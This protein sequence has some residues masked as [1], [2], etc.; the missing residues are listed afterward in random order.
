[1]A[2]P[3]TLLNQQDLNI[4]E[5]INNLSDEEKNKLFTENPAAKDYYDNLIKRVEAPRTP[6]D[7][8]PTTFQSSL[9]TTGKGLK[10]LADIAEK[11]KEKLP[12]INLTPFLKTDTILD[13][14]KNI[15]RPLG[16]W[17]DDE[18][19]LQAAANIGL[20]VNST[21]ADIITRVKSGFGSRQLSFEDSKKLLTDQLGKAPYYVEDIEG[22]GTVF[23]AN[24]GDR[25][26]AFNRPGADAGDI[27][28]FIAE[29]ALPLGLDIT[30]QVIATKTLK[31]L[32]VGV[33]QNITRGTAT[34]GASGIAT[35]L[36]EL[37]KL[38]AGQQFFGLNEGTSYI[39]LMKESIEPAL[40][41]GAGTGVFNSL[42]FIGRGVYRAIKGEKMPNDVINQ[43]NEM[44]QNAKKEAN[45]TLK[46]NDIPNFKPTLGQKYKSP[47]LLALEDAFMRV[48]GV[49]PNVSRAYLQNLKDNE[50]A[51]VDFATKLSQEYGEEFGEQAIE[52]FGR[53]FKAAAGD[54]KQ[55]ILDRVG[56]NLKL[57]Q[58]IAGTTIKQLPGYQGAAGDLGIGLYKDLPEE[59][60]T[61]LSNLIK[62][63]LDAQDA[64]YETV[65]QST[66]VYPAT[67]TKT[68]N[69]LSE[70]IESESPTSLFKALDDPSFAKRLFGE[71]DT[72]S[73][74]LLLRLANKDAQGR[75]TT[76]L[77]LGELYETR[78]VL[79]L[80]RGGKKDI[81]LN[82]K[83]VTK[84]IKSVDQDIQASLNKADLKGEKV[85]LGNDQLSPSEAWN[86]AKNEY[87]KANQLARKQFIG[88]LKQG[89]I[90]PSELFDVTM[91]K[92]VKG[93]RTNEY[94]DDLFEVLELGDDALI[95]DLRF[96]FGERLKNEIA[97]QKPSARPAAI[98]EFLDN[99]SGIFKRLYPTKQDQKIFRVAARDLDNVAKA[100]VSYQ[101]AVE[102]INNRFD[103]FLGPED[104]VITN[105]Y[106]I[107]KGTPDESKLLLN[108]R[109][110]QLNKILRT[111]PELQNQFRFHLQKILLNDITTKDPF[112][113][114]I[115]DL[116]SLIKTI[117][118]P[119]FEK[120]YGIFFDTKYINNLKKL[121]ETAQFSNKRINSKIPRE[122]AQNAKDIV[123]QLTMPESLGQRASQFIFG[124]LNRFSVRF[125]LFDKNQ[126]ERAFDNLTRMITDEDVLESFI[127]NRYKSMNTI[128]R[129]SPIGG[130]IAR[131]YDG[132][133]SDDEIPEEVRLIEE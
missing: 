124:P 109:R 127:E 34:A 27:A 48:P 12:N 107:F 99:H 20:D 80:I 92:S 46:P 105:I 3:I 101:E 81:D 47:E 73:K 113:G 58:Q 74:D 29:E 10:G 122:N 83:E 44:L 95:T 38:A 39:D 18:E 103:R 112:Y 24:K 115:I 51:L 123:R 89:K 77:S 97:R 25:L 88:D 61:Y 117:D 49:D 118:D 62:Q 116:D 130:L 11:A 15:S 19:K 31:N 52:V 78:K 63:N 108:G 42:A 119:N 132:I 13:A 55:A 98:K 17:L 100:K 40:F 53:N 21:G 33:V 66:S 8:D 102:K 90:L 37:T 7:Y 54:K 45:S 65:K 64:L 125:R 30:A 60:G 1:M 71:D 43:M 28:E 120:S 56:R 67:L 128:K 35:Y 110:R 111:S 68:R 96:A 14:Y 41:A 129:T 32:P 106:N 114:K 23:Q 76:P 36:G 82:P 57:N 84:L 75:F 16:Q 59:G 2:E 69:T 6:V 5:S 86:F 126:A 50:E 121:A 22:V 70:L 91:S 87:T 93:A 133:I 104:D 72:A 4:V 85:V 9:Q 79:N 26:V 131:N 94:F